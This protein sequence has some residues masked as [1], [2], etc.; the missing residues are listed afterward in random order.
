MAL[1][2]KITGWFTGE[3]KEEL[4]N[5][6]IKELGGMVVGHAL[7]FGVG[8]LAAATFNS[9]AVRDEV[10]ELGEKLKKS[11]SEIFT[12]AAVQLG[13]S[14]VA[15]TP[16]ILAGM[17]G[18]FQH[19][20][21]R[22]EDDADNNWWGYIAGAAAGAAGMA[23][24]PL[25]IP[26]VGH[27]ASG[28]A[29]GFGGTYAYNAYSEHN[30][31]CKDTISVVHD[32]MDMLPHANAKDRRVI[33]QSF[34]ALRTSQASQA[35]F[36]EEHLGGASIEAGLTAYLHGGNP[37]LARTFAEAL[38]DPLNDQLLRDELDVLALPTLNAQGKQLALADSYSAAGVTPAQFVV[39]DLQH[40]VVAARMPSRMPSQGVLSN[41]RVLAQHMQAA[42]AMP[43]GMPALPA[44]PA[45]EGELG[46]S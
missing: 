26:F 21:E 16:Q 15:I 14:P 22:T 19:M 29:F 27:M 3:K 42:A 36:E 34:L 8:D 41:G 31:L 1:L 6:E 18:V 28:L 2:E 43:G 45:K 7:P 32:A 25:P 38:F 20:E 37:K 10:E 11:H 5:S 12:A 33:L 39:G 40:A 9:H 13:V 24:L 30:K 35:A 4:E 23:F 44:F 46:I 17:P